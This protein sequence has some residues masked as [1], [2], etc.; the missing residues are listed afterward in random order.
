MLLALLLGN[1][2]ALREEVAKTLGLM[3]AADVFLN[4][5][6][7][8]QIQTVLPKALQFCGSTLGITRADLAAISPKLGSQIAEYVN[9]GASSEGSRKRKSDPSHGQPDMDE[10]PEPKAAPKRKSRKPAPDAKKQT[11]RKAAEKDGAE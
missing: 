3:M 5:K 6:H 10:D 4:K 11:K 2:Q 9:V 1:V 7:A 8:A